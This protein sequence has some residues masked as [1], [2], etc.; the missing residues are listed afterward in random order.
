M[1]ASSTSMPKGMNNTRYITLKSLLYS[2]PSVP[3]WACPFPFLCVSCHD[4]WYLKFTG[5]I[6]QTEKCGA[7]SKKRS[8]EGEGNFHHPTTR[9]S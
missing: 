6:G 2:T 1:K 3:L 5:S 8:F 7:G 4:P 9:G